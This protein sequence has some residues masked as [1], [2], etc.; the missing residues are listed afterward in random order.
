MFFH[1]IDLFLDAFQR[2]APGEIDIGMLAGHRQGRIRRAREINAGQ[3]STAQWLAK[4][5]LLELVELAL[6]IEGRVFPIALEDIEEFI[7]ALIARIVILEITIGA[8]A[9][10]ATTG[11]DIQ[12]KSAMAD[13]LQRG[14]RLREIGG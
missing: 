9:G 13:T 7:R 10:A 2:L 3:G 12:I 1:A 6:M 11:D 14:G 8:L 4:A 5:A